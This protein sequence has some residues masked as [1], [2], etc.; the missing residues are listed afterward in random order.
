M[1]TNGIKIEFDLAEM[2]ERYDRFASVESTATWSQALIS[3]EQAFTK[4]IAVVAQCDLDDFDVKAVKTDTSVDVYVTDGREGG[5][6]ISW[7]VSQAIT[8]TDE[9]ERRVTEVADCDECNQFCNQCLLL[10]RTPG[11]YLK[12]DLLHRKM[13]LSMVG[14][15][16]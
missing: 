14:E 6:G 1:R 3:M 11:F 7:Q 4:S 10:E 5:N 9:F 13:L 16:E 2:E 8:K 12:N 15:G